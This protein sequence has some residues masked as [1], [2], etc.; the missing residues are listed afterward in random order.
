MQHNQ[1]TTK[2]IKYP[3]GSVRVKE[4]QFA[5]WK[6]S[7]FT[8][9]KEQEKQH[10][11]S[12]LVRGL[13]SFFIEAGDY[14]RLTKNGRVVMSN[15]KMEIDTNRIAYKEAKG[16]VLVAGLGMGMILDAIISKPEVDYVR[17]I[18]ID[19]NLIDNVGLLYKDNPKVEIIHA[20]ILNYKP[21]ES[22]FY[23][24]IWFDIWTDISAN[25][26]IDMELLA[27]NFDKHYQKVS[28]WSI[29]LLPPHYLDNKLMKIVR[30][31]KKS[32]GY[33]E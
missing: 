14:T 28:F 7:N 2:Q 10:N 24:F 32:K 8:V 30:K 21:V 18:E 25:N 4:S 31:L 23:D 1:E 20:D 27:R 26:I 6:I 29:N 3:I 16:R 17:V 13:E 22:E 5:D 19:K 12:C 15:T 11:V 33:C 9:S